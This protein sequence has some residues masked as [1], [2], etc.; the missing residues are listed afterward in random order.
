MITAAPLNAALFPTKSAPPKILM[1]S[2][3]D[4]LNLLRH[5]EDRGCARPATPKGSSTLLAAPQQAV[6]G[7]ARIQ[8]E[9]KKSLKQTENVTAASQI[10]PNEGAPNIGRPPTQQRFPG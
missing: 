10:S 6:M 2:N 1:E 7:I 4:F 8:S 9:K 3:V 5:R